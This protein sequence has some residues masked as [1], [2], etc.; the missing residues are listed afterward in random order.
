MTKTRTL[1]LQTLLLLCSYGAMAQ[2]ANFSG[3]WTRNN[4]KTD[5]GAGSSINSVP[6]SVEVSQADNKISITRTSKHADGKVFTYTESL[7]FD[8]SV[9][10]SVPIPNLNK[11][12][13]ISWSADKAGMVE[14]ADYTSEQGQPVQKATE[15]WTLSDGGKTLTIN[16]VLTAG[17]N[18]YN[19]HEVFD[20][21]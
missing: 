21:N 4:E 5:P 17:D 8:G 15:T 1:T 9:T 19:L 11:K 2:S 16:L 20:K 12:A 7:S 10:S 13:K 6:V 18:V 3:K 14:T